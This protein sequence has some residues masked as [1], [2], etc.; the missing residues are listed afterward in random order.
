MRYMLLLCVA[1]ATNPISSAPSPI[2][3]DTPP[4]RCTSEVAAVTPDGADNA[5]DATVEVVFTESVSDQPWSLTVGDEP[6]DVVLAADGL[7][8]TFVPTEAWLPNKQYTIDASVC[9]SQ[10]VVTFATLELEVDP[11]GLSGRMFAVPFA[12]A[13]WSQPSNWD[14]IVELLGMPVPELLL[15]QVSEVPSWDELTVHL[16][17]G[18][19][20]G[21]EVMQAR[22]AEVAALDAVDFAEN[23]RVLTPETPWSVALGGLGRMDFESLTLDLAVGADGDALH[24]VLLLGLVDTRG[25]K[26]VGET[27]AYT[28]CD[29]EYVDCVKCA[30]GELQCVEVEITAEQGVWVE[31]A[32]LDAS[33][34]PW[35]DPDCL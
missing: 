16:T 7:S 10:F 34:D 1:C 31:G 27:G 19:S 17:A 11:G 13:R 5:L 32:A 29:T 2:V 33:Y 6:G 35:A 28:A 26:L 3:D 23:P 24:D 20:W 9:D 30:D 8:A 25:L 12:G 14:I 4:D 18:L 22:C 15:F 21:G